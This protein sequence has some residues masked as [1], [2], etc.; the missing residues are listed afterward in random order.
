MN[1]SLLGKAR[2]FDHQPGWRFCGSFERT[3]RD[4]YYRID[5]MNCVVWGFFVSKGCVVVWM[6]GGRVNVRIIV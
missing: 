2:L 4:V 6:V 5:S 1:A 3:V